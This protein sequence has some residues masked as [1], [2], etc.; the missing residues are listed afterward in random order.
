MTI[1]RK[2]LFQLLAE[3][4]DVTFPHSTHLN[5]WKQTLEVVD[6][7]CAAV[8]KIGDEHRDKP[9][10][11]SEVFLRARAEALEVRTRVRRL[12]HCVRNFETH[13]ESLKSR[14]FELLKAV[15]T[16]TRSGK[17][18]QMPNTVLHEGEIEMSCSVMIEDFMSGRSVQSIAEEWGLDNKV[19]EEVL[20]TRIVTAQIQAPSAA[21]K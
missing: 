6:D 2:S 10:D 16:A 7:N 15:D 5:D 3:F 1:K 18:L 20:R 21:Q 13:A 4:K 19:V 8:I 14:Y 9:R 11:N 12:R 17:V